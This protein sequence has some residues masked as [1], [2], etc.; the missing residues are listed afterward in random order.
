MKFLF[1]LHAG[2]PKKPLKITEDQKSVLEAS[3]KVR[4]FLNKTTRKEL[5]LQTGLTKEQVSQWFSRTRYNA[6]EGKY[7][8]SLFLSEFFPWTIV[9]YYYIPKHVIMHC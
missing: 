9:W 3:F 8:P 4:F 6:R 2:T 7:E 5:A 1:A